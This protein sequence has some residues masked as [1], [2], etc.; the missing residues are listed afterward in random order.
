AVTER[1]AHTV[2]VVIVGIDENPEA[3]NTEY[4]YIVKKIDPVEGVE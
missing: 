3:S 2:G 1:D 4:G